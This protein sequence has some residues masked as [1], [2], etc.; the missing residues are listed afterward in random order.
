MREVDLFFAENVGLQAKVSGVAAGDRSVELTGVANN[1]TVAGQNPRTVTVPPAGTVQTDFSITCVP[2]T[3]TVEVI[4]E[5]GGVDIDPNGYTVR[6]ETVADQAIGVNDTISVVGVVDG[7]RTVELMNVD[8]NCTVAGDNPRTVTV[9][10]EGTVQTKFDVT[11]SQ[12]TGSVAVTASTTGDDLDPD[13]YMVSIDGGP[14]QAI[15]A[16]ETIN[17]QDVTVGDRSVELSGVAGNCTVAGNNP[18]T[19]TVPPSG[20]CAARS[21]PATAGR[22][23]GRWSGT[24]TRAS[25]GRPWT[26]RSKA[27][28]TW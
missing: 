18:R 26:A 19:V 9:P 12:I 21:A 24:G 20:V 23:P 27:S 4:A 10:G 5:T 28:T 11:C 17:I 8:A 25:A 6:I 22:S 2:I 3:G 1:C 16:N 14:G 13:G 15:Q 7:D